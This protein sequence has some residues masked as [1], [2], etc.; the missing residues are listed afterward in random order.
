MGVFELEVFMAS[1][2]S[3]NDHDFQAYHCWTTTG[4]AMT[5]R[6]HEAEEKSKEK[7][8]IEMDDRPE[9]FTMQGRFRRVHL[10]RPRESRF[11]H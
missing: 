3:A 5:A 10:H 2:M 8:K 11:G 7:K 4:F 1:L 6:G 9:F